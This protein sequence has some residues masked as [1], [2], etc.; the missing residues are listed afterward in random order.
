MDPY[1]SPTGTPTS[2]SASVWQLPHQHS[3]TAAFS[4]N[5]TVQKRYSAAASSSSNCT[6]EPVAL[7]PEQF[8][9][10]LSLPLAK[11][12]AR[13]SATTSP[14]FE[15]TAG[16]TDSKMPQIEERMKYLSFANPE[17]VEI[18]FKGDST[19]ED[20]SPM[21]TQDASPY[22]RHKRRGEDLDTD[23]ARPP[24][25]SETAKRDF[26]KS[27]S[28]RS[29]SGI[30]YSALARFYDGLENLLLTNNM[31]GIERFHRL[32]LSKLLQAIKAGD[33]PL[34]N[35]WNKAYGATL[36]FDLTE[37][38]FQAEKEFQARIQRAPST[39]QRAPSTAQRALAMPAADDDAFSL[40][41]D[42]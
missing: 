29:S 4:G 11:A 12:A 23:S 28:G 22:H 16:D 40:E 17:A 14:V 37:E 34:I 24:S 31:R 20:D 7:N 33:K 35:A 32:A 36:P 19:S 3:D 21:P 42:T 2:T 9:N 6:T 26:Q 10:R 38:E 27:R 41:K 30:E 8:S 25:A 5:S 15:E 13:E 18:Q 39:A 1:I